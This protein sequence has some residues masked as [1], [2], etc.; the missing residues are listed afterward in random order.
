MSN[1]EFPRDEQYPYEKFDT[2]QFRDYDTEQLIDYYS[3]A[4][5]WYDNFE[6]MINEVH[7]THRFLNAYITERKENEQ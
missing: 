2:F 7:H 6:N 4:C 1:K 3:R 5:E